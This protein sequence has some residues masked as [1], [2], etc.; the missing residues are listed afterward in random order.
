MQLAIAEDCL[1]QMIANL[2]YSNSSLFR[3]DWRHGLFFLKEN[4]IQLAQSV[5]INHLFCYLV[6]AVYLLNNLT[7]TFL[8]YCLH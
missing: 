3:R 1:R 2:F 5:N 6:D 7:R 8:D 4:W